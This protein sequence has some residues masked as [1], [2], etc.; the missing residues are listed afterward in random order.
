MSRLLWRRLWR[1]FCNRQI[2]DDI[3]K[4]DIDILGKFKERAEAGNF[5][6]PEEGTAMNGYSIF[7]FFTKDQTGIR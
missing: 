2:G 6:D 7:T 1:N 4:A 5:G 3:K